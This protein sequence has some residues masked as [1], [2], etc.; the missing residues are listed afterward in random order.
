MVRRRFVELAVLV[1]ALLVACSGPP[2]DPRPHYP[3]VANADTRVLSAEARAAMQSFDEDSGSVVFA[4]AA[5][6]DLEVGNVVVS[7]PTPAAPYGFL[8]RVT[9]V[10]DSVAGQLTVETEPASLDMAL[11]S[12]TLYETFALT[13]DDIVSLEYYVDGVRLFDPSDPLEQERLAAAGGGDLGPLELPKG[14]LGWSFPDVVVYDADGQAAT[15]NDRIVLNGDVGV[16]PIFDLDFALNCSWLCYDTNPY[17]KFEMGGQVIA[18]LALESTTP[19]AV[20]LSKKVPLASLTAKAI[21]FWIGPVPVVIVPKLKL[22]LQVDGSVGFSLG[23]E[24]QETLTLKLGAQY[25]DGDWSD[26]SDASH[27]ELAQPVKGDSF[28][29]VLAKAKVKGAVRGELLLYGVVGAFA[30]L[31]PQVGIDVEYPRDPIW[32]LSAGLDANVGVMVDVWLFEKEWAKNVMKLEWEVAQAGNTPPEVAILS[33]ATAP[34]GPNGVNLRAAV[35]D[36]EDGPACC[37]TTFRSS[38]TADGTGGLLGTVSGSSTPEVPVAFASTG[39]RTITVT[40]VDSGGKETAKTLSLDVVNTPPQ[41]TITA[42]PNGSAFFAGQGVRFRAF[43][44]DPNEAG[45]AVP[46]LQ[47]TWS[48]G[49]RSWTGCDVMLDSGFAEQGNPEITLVAVDSNGGTATAHTSLLVLPA[50][51]NYPPVVGTSSPHDFITVGQFDQLTLGYDA[52]D[53]EENAMSAG[54]WDALMDYDLDT[55][56]GGPLYPV[57][58]DAQNRWSISQLPGYE[59]QVCGVS[60]LVRLR[61]QVTDAASNVGQDYVVLRFT[62]LC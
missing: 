37:T 52:L 51:A 23:Y 40:A 59:T 50:P 22:V 48:G 61:V 18:R 9:A 31:V 58:P 46:C 29:H 27:E 53:P 44:Y 11:E 10:D 7:E 32:K 24:V 43:T 42:P 35:S 38:N 12:G 41:V 14:F 49:G 1:L 13:M 6:P 60:M 25:K 8:R 5:L 34:V 20:T 55:G 15:K 17:F 16:K 33:D 4:G 26:L 54:T 36:A 3:A 2:P 56:T 47:L 45:F 57:T 39:K 28:V 62:S 19:G 21:T 30:E